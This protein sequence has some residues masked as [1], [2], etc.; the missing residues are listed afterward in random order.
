MGDLVLTETE[1]GPVMKKLEESGIEITALH[2]HLLR[3]QPST[4]YMHVLGN[5]DPAILAANLHDALVL[6][7]TP[8]GNATPSASSQPTA[9]GAA[10][11]WANDDA[12]KLAGGLRAALD[13][14]NLART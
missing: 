4:L 14:V 10:H 8:L 3:A 11:F 13:K 9:A 12:T 5:G 2:N 6:S 7:G 1:V